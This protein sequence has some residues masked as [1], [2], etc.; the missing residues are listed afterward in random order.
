MKMNKMQAKQRPRRRWQRNHHD[1]DDD[2]EIHYGWITF[3]ETFMEMYNNNNR[4]NKTGE[5]EREGGGRE[6]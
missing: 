1:I 5:R 6:K 2:D 3:Y 4:K